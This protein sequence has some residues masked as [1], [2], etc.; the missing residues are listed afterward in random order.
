MN[1]L[2][3]MSRKMLLRIAGSICIG[4]LG[5][6]SWFC[7]R[8]VRPCVLNAPQA[9]CNDRQRHDRNC[10]TNQD[11]FQKQPSVC[12]F[13]FSKTSELSFHFSSTRTFST[14]PV[15]ANGLW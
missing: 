2:K 13:H 1:R 7:L 15:N 8:A 10:D 9:C 4:P 14:S 5:E 3:D 12:E 11:L 6:R